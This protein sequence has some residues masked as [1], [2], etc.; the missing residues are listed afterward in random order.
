MA[1]PS[2]CTTGR[3]PLACWPTPRG[4]SPTGS[5]PNNYL[6]NAQ[7]LDPNVGFY[8]LRARYYDPPTGRFISPDPLPGSIFDPMS[9]HPYTYANNDPVNKSDP[10]GQ[11][12]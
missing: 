9:L 2:S 12:T 7:Q 5:T 4:R 11:Y 3:C 8:Y 6:Y 10:S 1:P